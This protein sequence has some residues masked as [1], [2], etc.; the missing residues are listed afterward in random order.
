MFIPAKH[1]D[2]QFLIKFEASSVQKPTACEPKSSI[3]IYTY[4]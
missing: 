1:R 2:I 3:I 4:K